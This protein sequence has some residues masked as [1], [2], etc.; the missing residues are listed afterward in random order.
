MLQEAAAASRRQALR[1]PARGSGRNRQ[2]ALSWL[3]VAL[4]LLLL[5][6]LQ[7]PL[8]TLLAPFMAAWRAAGGHAVAR[9]RATRAVQ[10]AAVG[11]AV[12][13]RRRFDRRSFTK[14]AH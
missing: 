8:L 2:R 14:A 9:R 3:S 11:R 10:L 7:A 6:L 4:L 5:L 12:Q 13:A 1:R